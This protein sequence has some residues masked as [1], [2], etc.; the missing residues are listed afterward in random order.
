[1]FRPIPFAHKNFIPTDSPP[2]YLGGNGSVKPTTAVA[3]PFSA[4]PAVFSFTYGGPLVSYASVNG[5][6]ILGAGLLTVVLTFASNWVALIPWRKSIGKH[7]TERARLYHPVR[8]AAA[9]NLWAI[10]ALLALIVLICSGDD[11]LLALSVALASATGAAAGVWPMSREVCPRIPP[12]DLLRESAWGFLFRFLFWLVMVGIVVSMPEAFNGI[13]IAIGTLAVALVLGWAL[14][15]FVRV[16]SLTGWLRPAPERL[17]TIVNATSKR[18]GVPVRRTWLMRSQS[19]QAYA[20]P[21]TG[22]LMFAQRLLDIMSDDE[23]AA[24][25]AHEL[26]H[27]A[28]PKS[29]LFRRSLG[30]SMLLPWIFMKPLL[31]WLGP[32]AFYIALFGTILVPRFTRSFSRKMEVRADGMAKAMEDESGTYARALARLYEDRMVPAVMAKS[33]QT[34][35]DLYERLLAAGVVPDY[36]RPQPSSSLAWHGRLV[37]GAVGLALAVYIGKY[38]AEITG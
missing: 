1:M 17:Q 21:A 16:W 37:A 34:H 10:P 12:K 35:P 28:E 6:I 9:V 14:G 36:P 27:L 7:W 15:G 4:E 11:V 3:R 24:I 2:G 5:L 20:I 13:T 31:H 23:V 26:S 25:C 19:A 38:Y 22:E 33:K 30:L 18:M 8:A 29:A 32:L